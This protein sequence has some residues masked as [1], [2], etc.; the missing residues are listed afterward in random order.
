M[1]RR[2]SKPDV[3]KMPSYIIALMVILSGVGS[4]VIFSIISY[5]FM[6]VVSALFGIAVTATNVFG[7]AIAFIVFEGTVSYLVFRNFWKNFR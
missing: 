7:L 5:I 4:F 3:F 1:F 6:L 2:M